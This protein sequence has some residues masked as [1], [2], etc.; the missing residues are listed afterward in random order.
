MDPMGMIFFLRCFRFF[1]WGG[2]IF[3]GRLSVLLQVTQ[4][5]GQNIDRKRSNRLAANVHS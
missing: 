1:F 5:Q 2:A 4:L 3:V